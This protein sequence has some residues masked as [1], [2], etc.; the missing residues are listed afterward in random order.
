MPTRREMQERRF[1]LRESLLEACR[2]G[3]L[4]PN[5]AV[6]PMRELARRHGVSAALACQV[7]Q[8]LVEEGVLYSR[9]GAGTFVGHSP[10]KGG[11]P[12]LFIR[13][14]LRPLPT[15]AFPVQNG[16][17][18]RIAQLGG[19]CL[20]LER[21][22]VLRYLEQGDLP[23]LSGVFEMNSAPESAALRNLGVPCVAF[24][25]LRPDDILDRVQFDDAGGGETATRHLLAM[26]HRRIAF[27]GLHG[28][29]GEAGEFV[30]SQARE[31]GWQRALRAAR[32]DSAKLSFLPLRSAQFD[33]ASQVSVARETALPLVAQRSDISAVLATNRFAAE[34]LWEALRESNV[35]PAQWPSIVCFD[36]VDEEKSSVISYLR[37][38]WDEVGRQ[39][40]QILWERK[41]GRLSGPPQ[42][43]L[44]AMRLIPRLS[45]R[46]QWAQSS[47]LAARQT[48][49]VNHSPNKRSRNAQALAA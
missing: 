39:A 27:L 48:Q 15:Q 14:S 29:N 47:G 32:Q 34:G 24:G 42:K 30:W 26:G 49:G 45:C 22:E 6:P 18:D 1:Q 2:D 35:S 11:E 12:F 38:P 10:Q 46:P 31:T 16:F 25:T 40:A 37:L 44:V 41:T 19:A 8:A 21:D 9:Q 20:S 3:K 28:R 23:Q 4:Q 33:I 36:E 17:E 13:S 43:R 5:Q 7:V